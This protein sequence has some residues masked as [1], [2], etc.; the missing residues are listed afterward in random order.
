MGILAL[1]A[2]GVVAAIYLYVVPTAGRMIA[3]RMPPHVEVRLGK[4]VVDQ[5]APRDEQCLDYGVAG[6]IGF[7]LENLSKHVEGGA[8]QFKAYV[9]NRDQINAFA[10]PGGSIVVYSGL[11]NKTRVPEELAAIFAHEITHVIQKHGTHA[12]LRALT[13]QTMMS[14]VLGEID[15]A[16]LQL[17]GHLGDLRYAREDEQSADQ[18]A[19]LL[20]ERSRLDPRAIASIYQALQQSSPEQPGATSYLS[21]HPMLRDRV[22]AAREWASRAGYLPVPLLPNQPW[23]PKPKSPTAC[24]PPR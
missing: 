19:M 7:I 23:P 4:A 6:P 20:M 5:L 11:L 10:A 1:A 9:A 8:Y 16:I 15:G 12:V 22:D 14:F 3:Q 21:S 24:L 13:F 18:G 17:A 2:A